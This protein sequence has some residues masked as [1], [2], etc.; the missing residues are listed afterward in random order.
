MTALTTPT[1]LEQSETLQ[2]LEPL[3]VPAGLDLLPESLRVVV[4][5]LVGQALETQRAALAAAVSAGE[6]ET[7]PEASALA[8]LDA[9]DEVQRVSFFLGAQAALGTSPV[10][11]PLVDL[12]RQASTAASLVDLAMGTHLVIETLRQSVLE[13]SGRAL[14]WQASNALQPA[15]TRATLGALAD[16]MG[17]LQRAEN[18]SVALAVRRLRDERAML[19]AMQTVAFDARVASWRRQLA[20]VLHRVPLQ[21]ALTPSLALNPEVVLACFDGRARALG[22]RAV[23]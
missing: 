18:R 17:C 8:K 11:R 22:C 20:V 2:A 14:G 9:W 7:D 19:G 12:L 15:Q 13:V 3:E 21:A 4:A 5:D 23:S 16:A 10:N 1:P 6:L